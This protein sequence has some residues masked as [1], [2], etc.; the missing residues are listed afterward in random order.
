MITVKSPEEIWSHA[1]SVL[2]PEM[3]DETF[4][5]WLKPITV[6]GLDKDILT[7]NV[8]N[9]FFSDWVKTHYKQRLE[10]LISDFMGSP[11]QLSFETQVDEPLPPIQKAA[12]PP[13]G[14]E[15]LPS[16]KPKKPLTGRELKI[17]SPYGFDNFVVGPSNR[18]AEAAS[19]A[20][21]RDPGRSY[22]PLFIYGGVG[23]GKTHLLHSIGQRISQTKDNA[24]VLYVPSEQFINEFINALRYERMKEFRAKYRSLD[25]LLI[26]DIQFL[27]GKESS[28]EEFF[29]TFNSLYD[30]RKQ[31]VICS[32]RPPKETLVGDRL[33]SRF[34]WGVIADIQPPDLETR[35]AILKKKSDE[36]KLNAPE[37]VILFV[38]THIKS[39]IRELE[40]SLTRIVACAS[41]TGVPLTVDTARSVLKDTLTSPDHVTS[42]TIPMV[43]KVVARQFNLDLRDMKSKRRSDA[44]AF[45]RQIAMYISRT[46]T[47]HSTTE[48]GA[49]FGGKDHTTVMH[50]CNK[51]KSKMS[52]D[53][54]FVALVNK[55]TQEIREESLLTTP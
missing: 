13:S 34:E 46:L 51:I 5:L 14:V 22:N 23:L 20:V 7:L 37:D 19:E 2:R 24:K 26:D 50:A 21:A 28:Q 43:Q 3:K 45:P 32:D 38:A 27:M 33:V 18:F 54:Y 35:I 53:P 9:N 4:D 44:I 52:G 39:N 12:T 17:Q 6:V 1:L 41:L 15:P 8:P 25:C 11:I 55:I 10:T 29:Y 36:T 47:E 40:G 42:V 49:S 16:D 30:L 31:I 48:I